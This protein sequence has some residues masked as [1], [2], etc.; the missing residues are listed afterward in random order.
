MFLAPFRPSSEAYSCNSNLWFYGWQ[1]A[2]AA[3][4]VVVGPAGQTTTNN[5]ATDT[6]Q[7]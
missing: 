5:A 6:R 2:V 3:L 4:L 1:V 7:P